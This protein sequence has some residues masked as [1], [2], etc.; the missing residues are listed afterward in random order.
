M[1]K[2][3]QG[4]TVLLVAIPLTTRLRQRNP[5]AAAIVA[6]DHVG[7]KTS[8][9]GCITNDSNRIFRHQ[10]AFAHL[11]NLQ[12]RANE[13]VQWLWCYCTTNTN[14]ANLTAKV[15]CHCS[16]QFDFT[17]LCP[18]CK[19][20]DRSQL[21]DIREVAMKQQL[22]HFRV[23]PHGFQVDDTHLLRFSPFQDMPVFS[24][25]FLVA[26]S[27]SHLS[28]RPVRA[29]R[30]GFFVSFFGMTEKISALCRKVSPTVAL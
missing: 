16:V 24:I 11:R 20:I 26:L 3:C 8:K 27:A 13:I 5:S 19:D 22:K 28:A 17:S 29:S 12:G 30:S 9:G 15:T 25:S 10:Q 14:P 23:G 1:E 2:S 7:D 6:F 21:R 18:C 4:F